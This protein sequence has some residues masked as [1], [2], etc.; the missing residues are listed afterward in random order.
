MMF[1]RVM[2]K[3]TT[4]NKDQKGQSLVEIALTMP[5]LILV[6]VGILD[7]G[8]A[9]FTFIALSD[10]AAEGAAYAAIHPTDTTQIVARA[11]D[12]STG[13]VTFEPDMVQVTA[14]GITAGSP[15]T[16]TIEYEYQILTPLMSSFVSQ[17]K[18]KMRSIVA[19][20]IIND[21]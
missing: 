14:N 16:V 19:Q 2:F 8:R 6:L 15:I 1:K 18:I 7:L 13:L 21:L 9:Y 3:R 4:L 20:P 11:V 12:S 5:I 17:G 10:A